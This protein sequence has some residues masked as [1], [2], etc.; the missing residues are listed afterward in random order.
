MTYTVKGFIFCES[1]SGVLREGQ[2]VR[3]GE[4]SH[5]LLKVEGN[6]RKSYLRRPVVGPSGCTL[7]SG[8]QLDKQKKMGKGK[9]KLSCV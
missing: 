7:T 5:H 3:T 6:S 9:V 2:G 4:K 1:K 8:Q